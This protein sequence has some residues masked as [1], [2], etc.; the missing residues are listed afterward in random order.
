MSV[1][2][3]LSLYNQNISGD[4]DFVACFVARQ[5]LLESLL[6]RLR[7]AK[8]DDSGLHYVLIGPR[9]MGKTS[10]LRR[11]AIAINRQPELAARYVPLTFR[12]EQYNV[13]NLGDFWRNCG[14]ALAEWAEATGRNDLADR[15]DSALM[16]AAWANDDTSIEQL[17]AELATLQR[18]AIL[19]IDNIDLIL[20]A[21]PGES[22]WTLR[23]HLQARHGPIVIGAATQSLKQS[24][25]HDAAF[26]EFFQPLYLEPLD[27]HE[28][29][30]CMRALARGRGGD[31]V[32]VIDVLDK[33]PQ[34]LRTL[35]TLTGGNPRIL[36]LIY[37]LLE[38]GQSEVAMADLEILL[39]QV[40]PYY[41]ARVEEYQTPQQRAVIDGI[42][43]H[44]DP[45][46]T[47][48][49]ARV[50]NIATTTLSPLLIR[51][52]KD[53]LI[54]TVETSGS[55][56]GHQIV[57]RFFNIWYLLRHGTRRKKQKMR[58]L[59]VF[60]TNYYSSREL[61][62]IARSANDKGLRKGWQGDY[63]VAFEQALAR[64][65][66]SQ[67]GNRQLRVSVSAGAIP[68]QLETTIPENGKAATDGRLAEAVRLERQSAE[69]FKTANYDRCLALLDGLLARFADA[70]EPAL[71]EQVAMALVNKAVTLGQMGDNAAAISTLERLLDPSHLDATVTLEPLF[72]T[73]RIRLA[74]LLLDL[75]DEFTRAETLYR[76]AAFVSP[77][78]ANANLTWLYLLANRLSDAVNLRKSLGAL[79]AYGL[80]LLDAA[81]EVAKDNFG[82][83]TDSLASALGVELES[84][85]MDFSDDFDRLLRL[86]ESRGY[87]ERLIVWFET[88][89]IAD[90]L[91]PIYAA[92]KAYV[93]NEKVLLDVNP[94]VRR[95]AKA[96]YE[97]LDAP[98]RHRLGISLKKQQA[99]RG[100]RARRPT[101]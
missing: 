5:E 49:L 26:Y 66:P 54:E 11:I 78:L 43:L 76:D 89:G 68:T 12:E 7:A 40:T 21:L 22:T 62:E 93:R 35:H 6:R 15:L 67:M 86:A 84:G 42:A 69:F 17:N 81:I 50:T 28:T 99:T 58:W 92:F 16:T 63:A 82:S 101:S 9:G 59:V 60:L 53:G 98:R 87:G 85:A 94:E 25:D 33:Q 37:R 2:P 3:S 56:A 74:N 90:R 83:A 44:W 45:I 20:E 19:L 38:A 36:T 95:P 39:D 77:L 88:T 55:Y 14:E 65:S 32:H 13:L 8:P 73:A 71:R 4:D 10:L 48:D 46:T 27:E 34:R 52:R 47:G 80:A 75:Q 23:R 31:G 29:E 24:A 57:E 1:H 72:A 100:R 97:R 96:I 91:A 64:Q 18:R 51:L 70:R 61:A 79:P 41:K 30:K